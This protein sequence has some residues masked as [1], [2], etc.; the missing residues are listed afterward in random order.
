MLQSVNRQRLAH[1]TTQRKTRQPARRLPLDPSTR[2]LIVDAER[3]IGIALTFMLAA[4]GYAHV[5]AVRSARR[6]IAVTDL[7]R[8]AFVFLDLDLPARG[9]LDVARHLARVERQPVTRVIALTPPSGHEPR[10]LSGV[11]GV[12]SYLVKPLRQSDL[13][14]VLSKPAG[15]LEETQYRPMETCR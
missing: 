9:A 4:R 3:Q 6:A 10:E 15:T 11:A 13:D 7:Y 5:R 14:E 1:A 8:P 12:E 2:F